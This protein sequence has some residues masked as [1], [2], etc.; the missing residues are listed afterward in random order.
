M[1]N[2]NKRLHYRNISGVSGVW[3]DKRRRTY[4]VWITHSKKLIHLGQT[5]DFFEACCLRKAAE[6][7]LWKGQI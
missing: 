3:W 1:Q 7:Q 6:N 2:C 5:P 4:K